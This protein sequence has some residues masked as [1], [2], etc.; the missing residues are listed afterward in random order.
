MLLVGWGGSEPGS[1]L[2]VEVVVEVSLDPCCSRGWRGSEPGSMLLV[3][4]EV[5]V[6]LDPCC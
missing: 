1:M 2:L 3:E 6:S 5:E 4:V